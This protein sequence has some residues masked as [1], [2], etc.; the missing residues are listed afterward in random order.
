[1]G[2]KPRVEFSG[3]NFHVWARR[4]DRWPLFVDEADYEQYIQLL[5]SAVRRFGWILLAF[6]LMPPRDPHVT[7]L[8]EPNLGRGMHWLHGMYVRW[9]ND[10]HG[11]TGRLFEH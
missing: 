3:A 4:V 5:A 2:R 6:S 9:F 8:R 11:R 10:R 7:D 1:M